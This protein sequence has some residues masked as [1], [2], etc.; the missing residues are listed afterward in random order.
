MV[1]LLR[2]IRLKYKTSVAQNQTGSLFSL[3]V[4]FLEE[5][6]D[7]FQSQYTEMYIY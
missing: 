7:K 2:F 3:F 1:S 6:L 4:W 5:F